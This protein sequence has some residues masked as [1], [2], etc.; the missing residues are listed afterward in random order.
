MYNWV[1]VVVLEVFME[2][3][4]LSSFAV[5]AWVASALSLLNNDIYF[6]DDSVYTGRWH[7]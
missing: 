7:G 3:W 6:L 5:T 4:W 2:L 1:A